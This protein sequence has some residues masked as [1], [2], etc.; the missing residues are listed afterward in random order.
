MKVLKTLTL[1][2]LP[3]LFVAGCETP[4]QDTAK[5]DQAVTTAN[6]AKMA[7]EKAAASAADAA[8][9][10]RAAA[11]SADKAAAE[12]KLAGDKADRIF[13]TKLRK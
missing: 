7:A 8:R 3:L 10:A 1:V 5:L 6:D 11:T 2:A 12:A 4:A 9:A 13:R